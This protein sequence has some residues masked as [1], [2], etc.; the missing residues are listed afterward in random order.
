MDMARKTNR[1][2]MNASARSPLKLICPVCFTFD[3]IGVHR[4]PSAAKYPYGFL[5]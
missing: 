3:S 1:M 4:R 2:E 5:K